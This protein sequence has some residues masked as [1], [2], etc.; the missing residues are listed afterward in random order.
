[1]T[2]LVRFAFC[3]FS[4]FVT[5]NA[6]ASPVPA[7]KPVSVLVRP[8]APFEPVQITFTL[9][10]DPTAIQLPARTPLVEAP[11]MSHPDGIVLFRVSF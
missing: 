2:T 8:A 7:Q 4:L 5:A 6:A 3:A 9:P 11:L 10:V 1:M